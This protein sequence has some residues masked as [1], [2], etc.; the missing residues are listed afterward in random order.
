MTENINRPN[1]FQVKSKNFWIS[2]SLLNLFIVTVLGVILRSK[3]L[4]DLPIIDYN[5]LLNAHSHFAF[6]GWVTLA[7]VVLMV[8]A[9]LT[10]SQKKQSAYQFVFLGIFAST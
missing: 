2:L 8:N 3:S 5:H 6:G 4:F 7:L 1:H 9:F 10:E